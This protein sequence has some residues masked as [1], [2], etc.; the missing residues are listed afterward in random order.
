MDKRIDVIAAMI[1][2][3][4]TIYDMQELE[5]AYAPPYSSA[6]DPVNMAGFVADNVLSGRSKVAAWNEVEG[7]KKEGAFLLD[8]RTPEEVKT[9]TIEGAV[10]IPL[11]MIRMKLNDIPKDKKLLVFCRVGLRGYIAARI[12]L[13]MALRMCST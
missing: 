13:R 5:H 9:G 3:E 8:V 4:N 2:N 6:K 7:Y 1:Q 10:N 11:D 12:L